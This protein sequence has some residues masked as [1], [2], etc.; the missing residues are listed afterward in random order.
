[1]KLLASLAVTI[2]LGLTSSPALSCSVSID[3]DHDSSIKARH[4]VRKVEGEFIVERLVG[5]VGSDGSFAEGTIYAHILLGN[6]RQLLTFQPF[7][8]AWASCGLNHLPNGDAKGAFYIDRKKQDGRFEVLF[9][10]GEY[11]PQG[12][13]E[14]F[15]ETAQITKEPAR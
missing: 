5:S 4:D 10:E 6:G 3:A 1:M 13:Y 8:E 11:L 7:L 9:W 12:Q 14:H 15:P 2:T